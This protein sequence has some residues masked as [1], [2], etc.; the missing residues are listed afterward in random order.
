MQR[1][2]RNCPIYHYIG[3]FLGSPVTSSIT[4]KH[5]VL[6]NGPIWD[7]VVLSM[8]RREIWDAC[9]DLSA[10]E[11]FTELQLAARESARCGVRSAHAAAQGCALCV[12]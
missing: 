6:Y 2:Q 8:Y 3:S 11:C 10:V 9:L 7:S 12:L 1:A 4:G 5:C